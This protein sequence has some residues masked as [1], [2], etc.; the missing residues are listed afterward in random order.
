MEKVA[1]GVYDIG[2]AELTLHERHD[3]RQIRLAYILSVHN[4]HRGQSSPARP[5][6]PR[7]LHLH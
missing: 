4:R 1:V 2:L 6:S 3:V 7:Y 5:L